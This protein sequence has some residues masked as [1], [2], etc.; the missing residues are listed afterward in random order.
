MLLA[1]GDFYDLPGPL[2]FLYPPFAAVLAV[3]LALLPQTV[4]QIGWTAAG[5]LAL[6]AVLHRFGLTG[7]VLSLVSTAAIFFVQPV[8]QTLAFGQLGIFLVALVVLDLVP[9]P[10]VFSA[11]AAAGG[12]AHGLGGGDQAHPGDLRGLP[13][14]GRQAPRLRVAVIDRA[15]GDPG[16]RGDRAA[17]SYDFWSRLARAATPGWATA[18]STTRTSR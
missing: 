6:V 15:G 16:Q 14:A 12:R 5:A 13:V 18:S 2:Q 4:V 9:G 10:R 17:A 11:A 8:L 7:W 3:P 1:G